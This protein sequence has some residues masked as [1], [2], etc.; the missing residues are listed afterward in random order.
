MEVLVTGGTG[1]L[2]SH[3]VAALQRAGHRV[4]LL[5]RSPDRVGPNLSPLGVAVDDLE[6]ATGDVMDAQ[7]V[8]AA[9]E[10]CDAV[11]HSA[12]IYSLDSRREA[13]LLSVNVEGTRTVLEAAVRHGLDPI[14]Y[15]SSAVSLAPASP[16]APLRLDSPVRETASPYGRSKAEAER[17]VR[18]MQDEG[19]RITIVYPA[20]VWGSR[21]PYVGEQHR[22]AAEILKGRLPLLP[23]GGLQVVDARDVGTTIAAAMVPGQGARRYLVPG[24]FLTMTE[25]AGLLAQATGRKIRARTAPA[26][27]VRAFGGM[28]ELSQRF[29][30]GRAS[31]SREG[32]EWILGA[33]RV[34][35][36][37]TRTGLRIEPRDP[38]ETMASTARWLARDGEITPAQAGSLAESQ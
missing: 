27:A 6:I 29:R 22:L 32:I 36:S 4:R 33:Y 2:G 12:S 15:V 3:A 28:S 23:P 20:S 1:Y 8:E 31:V 11:V 5:V 25:I 13:E 34:D 26:F 19:A 9:M 16:G 17:L 14:V 30:R 7:S 37:A 10:G 21:D 38:K 24:S 35:D 18:R